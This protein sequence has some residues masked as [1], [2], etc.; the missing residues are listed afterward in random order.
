MVALRLLQ[1]HCSRGFRIW[2]MLQTREWDGQNVSGGEGL[3]LARMLRSH[4]FRLQAK[5]NGELRLADR[6]SQF[7]QTPSALEVGNAIE[8]RVNRVSECTVVPYKSNRHRGAG[9]PPSPATRPDMR[10]RIRRFG[11]LG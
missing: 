4:R 1:S 10:V 9:R 5:N 11:G 2:G 7:G 3:D 8:L 6:L